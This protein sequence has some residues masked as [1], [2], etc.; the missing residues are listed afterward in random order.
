MYSAI[1]FHFEASRSRNFSFISLLRF[2]ISLWTSSRSA[3]FS[4]FSVKPLTFSFISWVSVFRFS[5]LSSSLLTCVSN[6]SDLS[7][8]RSFSNSSIFSQIVVASISRSFWRNC[9]ELRSS[10]IGKWMLKNGY[11][12]WSKGNPPEFELIPLSGNRFKLLKC[13]KVWFALTLF[14]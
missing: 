7:F 6:Y 11:A 12:P 2:L 8:K 10:K 14:G 5:S 3:F 9:S 1:S 13:W 4:I